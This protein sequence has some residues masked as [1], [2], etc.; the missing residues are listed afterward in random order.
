MAGLISSTLEDDPPRP[1]LWQPETRQVKP[2][3]TVQWQLQKITE[4]GSPLMTQ[5]RSRAQDFAARRGL[6]N[7]SI[8]AGAGESA[9]LG[10]AMPIAQADAATHGRTA[11]ESLAYL[12]EARRVNVGEQNVLNRMGYE[13]RLRDLAIQRQN[14]LQQGNMR[15]ESELNKEMAR[16]NQQLQMGIM[17]HEAGLRQDAMRLQAQLNDLAA[18]RQNALQQGN[19]RL[20]AELEQNMARLN[21]QL[22]QGNMELQARLGREATAMEIDLRTKSQ[23]FLIELSKKFDDQIRNNAVAQQAW[24]TAQN[25]INAILAD[26]N[27]AQENKQGLINRVQDNTRMTLSAIEAARTINFGDLFRRVKI[28]AATGQ[29]TQASQPAVTAQTAAGGTSVQPKIDTMTQYV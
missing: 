9:A 21:Q 17:G 10:V 25:A 12:N 16:L 24:F 27:I 22:Q 7:S 29:V 28:P 18:Q 23:A 4:Q 5:A 19:M 20:V 1:A 15:L 6:I 8:A 3:E 14:A 2:E 26:P 13:A 11:A